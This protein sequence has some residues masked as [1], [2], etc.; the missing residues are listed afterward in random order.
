MTKNVKRFFAVFLSCMLIISAPMASAAVTAFD[1]DFEGYETGLSQSGITNAISKKYPLS[2][3]KASV[4]GGFNVINA[5][6]KDGAFS[7]VFNMKAE[8]TGEVNPDP[9]MQVENIDY[10]GKRVFSVDFEMLRLGGVFNFLFRE[11]SGST[12]WTDLFSVEATGQLRVFSEVMK[13]AS[14]SDIFININE[15]HNLVIVSDIV[16]GNGISGSAKAATVIFSVYLD[17]IKVADNISKSLSNAPYT[18]AAMRIG[19]STSTAVEVNID[20]I[21]VKDETSFD[22]SRISAI[23]ADN[24]ENV[25][26]SNRKFT[27][28]FGTIIDPAT[29][30]LSD[31]TVIKGQNGSEEPVMVVNKALISPREIEITISDTDLDYGTDYKIVLPN[32]I[33]DILGNTNTKTEFV[34]STVSDPD[35]AVPFVEITYPKSK[36]RIDPGSS[37]TITANAVDTDGTI[38]KA[39]FYNGSQLL[40][41]VTEAPYEHFWNNVPG[42]VHSITCRVYD[43]GNARK[44]SEAVILI[45]E[46]NQLPVTTLISPLPDQNFN[47]GKNI[48]L[49]A[50]A[51]DGN[52]ENIEKVEFFVDGIKIGEKAAA[53][54]IYVYENGQKGSHT[55]TA[56]AYDGTGAGAMSVP[57]SFEIV[58]RGEKSLAFFDFNDFDGVTAPLGSGMSEKGGTISFGTIDLDERGRSLK[59]SAP[60][61]TGTDAP[62]FVANLSPILTKGIVEV[63][64]DI[65][66]T[67]SSHTATMFIVRSSTGIFN[68]DFEMKNGKIR[69]ISSAD[70]G[71]KEIGTYNE[72]TW[73]RVKEVFDLTNKLFSVYLDDVCI[74]SDRKMASQ[75]LDNMMSVR[76]NHDFESGASE[77]AIYLDNFSVA[78]IVDILKIERVEFKDS[79]GGIIGNADTGLLSSISIKLNKGIL[80]TRAN[81]DN[82]KLVSGLISEPVSITTVFNS[83]ENEI[84]ITPEVPL[85]PS[86]LYTIIIG[87]ALRD[88]DS[89]YLEDE[90]QKK[91]LT[92]PDRFG[93]DSVSLINNG[94]IIENF[95][96]LSAGQVSMS[97]K[98]KNDTDT[99]KNI[100]MIVAYY[101]NDIIEKYSV[102]AVTIPKN[103]TPTVASEFISL[104]YSDLTD[105][106]IVFYIWDEARCAISDPII[107]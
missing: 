43:N 12:R 67:D 92:S 34:F 94:S 70:T 105:G 100:I 6:G 45:S 63:E 36:L 37:I 75:K 4:G 23:P 20:N 57:V 50:S 91:F 49:E 8:K 86:S 107:Y 79:L 69:I 95:S 89:L 10:T 90:Y 17:D 25:S 41:T 85:L 97:A 58:K 66:I 73:Y 22:F 51:T 74:A 83:E 61:G 40:G 54:Y 32:T 78:Q 16:S 47:F 18:G 104:T 29:L 5:V 33:K 35:N 56:R 1:E 76:V 88:F 15:W 28:D 48:N 11:V 98:I 99:D 9:Y 93:L 55:F 64:T 102:K 81:L 84:I 3:D 30:L 65:Y 31:I 52:N 68:G 96:Q 38:T 7:K 2:S 13:D 42:G 26:V 80:N 44:T 71:I 101:K 19:L 14:M 62:Y 106:K 72:N 27:L 77:G 24:A 53:P 39:E 59:L 60:T 21:S 103:Q 82:V 46:I 87:G